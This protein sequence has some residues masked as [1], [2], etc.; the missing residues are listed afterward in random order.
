[1]R[2]LDVTTADGRTLRVLD[3]GPADGAPVLVH[4]GTPNSRLLYGHDV[5]RAQERGVRMISYDRPGYGG[6]TRLA[7]RSVADCTVDVRAIADAL[8]LRRLA[9]WGWSGGGPH[10][11]A[12][13]ALL[14]DLVPAVGVLASPAPYEA[15]GLDYF[16]DMGEQNVEDIKLALEDKPAARAKAELDREEMLAADPAGLTEQMLTLLSAVDAAVM[17][18]EF[19]S[20]LVD[21]F[22]ASLAPGIDGWWDDGE[23]LLAPWGFELAAIRTPVLLMHG[24]HDRFVPFAHG[25]WLAEQI[26]GVE[27]MLSEDDGHLTLTAHHLE[28][29]HAWLLERL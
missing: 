22:R 14:E 1:M 19:G 4:N 11:L 16:D 17:T 20:Y 5:E 21:Y 24:R 7:G 3:A 26:P 2:E 29:L 8:G 6:S 28:R 25:Q 10:A 23:A 15:D 13:A 12:C 18:G 27:T 9:V